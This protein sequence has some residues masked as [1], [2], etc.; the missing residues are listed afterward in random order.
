MS[1]LA[2]FALSGCEEEITVDVSVTVPVEVQVLYSAQAPGRLVVG[3]DVPK[4]S[5][6]WY[7]L[8]VL[9]EP[10]AQPLVARLHHQGRG[11]AKAGTVRAWIVPAAASSACGLVT[12]RFDSAPAPTPA[13]AQG[14]GPVFAQA[15]G[16]AGCAGGADRVEVVVAGPPRA[17]GAD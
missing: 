13:F 17:K 2:L 1:L 4:S 15:T 5:V 11:C 9:C 16:A 3:L 6:G 8:G 10:G 7:S 14:T 12:T